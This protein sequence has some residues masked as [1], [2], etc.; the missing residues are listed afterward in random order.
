MSAEIKGRLPPKMA[1][2]RSCQQHVFPGTTTCPHCSAD[3]VAVEAAREAALDQAIA[4]LQRI[5]ALLAKP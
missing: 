1:R 5:E 3:I 2:C 4:A